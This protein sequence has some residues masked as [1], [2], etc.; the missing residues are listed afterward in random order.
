VESGSLP[1]GKAKEVR[2]EIDSEEK[3]AGFEKGL[4]ARRG[5]I[6]A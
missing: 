4:D 5:R 2:V 1:D 6:E 3:K